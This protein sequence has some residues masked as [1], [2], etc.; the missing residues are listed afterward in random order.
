MKKL[1]LLIVSILVIL[2]STIAVISL[3]DLD[4]R[5]PLGTINAG[6]GNTDNPEARNQWMLDRLKDPAT[7]E[8]PANIKHLEMEFAKKLPTDAGQRNLEWLS[9]GPYNIGGR[10]RAIAMDVNDE[11]RLIAGA[12]TGGV[13]LSEDAGQSW[14]RVTGPMHFPP[15]SCIVQ[16]KRPGKTHIWYYGTGEVRGGYISSQFYRGDG[17]YKS[18]DNGLTWQPLMST[19][20]NNPQATDSEWNFVSR[21]ALDPSVDSLDVIYAST[22]G[23]I[24]RSE[25]GGDTWVKKIGLTSPSIYYS[26]LAVT[27]TGVVYA[28]ADSDAGNGGLWRS[29]GGISWTNITPPGFP[30][31]YDKIV[32]GINP[33]NE[34]EIY[35]LG[36]TPGA[37]QHTQAF[38]GYEEDNS[39][40]K[41]TYVSGNGTGTGANW[42]NL[43]SN[44]PNNGTP[45]DNFYTQWSYN[46]MIAVSP[47]NPNVVMIGA[48]NLYRSTDGFTSMI[49]TTHIGGYWKGS[50]LPSGSWGSYLNH[51]PDQHALLFHPTDSNIIISGND[52]GLYRS[53]NAYDSIVAW[54]RLNN[55]YNTTQAYTVGFDRT[56][57]D[58]VLIGGFQDNANYFVN[59]ADTTALWTM[60]L[61]GDGSYMG[62]APNKD[63]YYLSINRGKIYKMDL[64][65]NG[66]VLDFVRIDPGQVNPDDYLFINPLLMDHNNAD[67]MYV[68]GGRKL[69]RH[70][71]LSS[72]PMTQS[73]DTIFTGW[74]TY[75][76]TINSGSTQISCLAASVSPANILWVGTSNRRLYKII[77]AHTGDPSWQQ[78]PLTTFP[79]GYIS[80]VAIH[81][82]NADT[83]VI[84]LSNYNMYSLFYT[85][86]GGD[87]WQKGAGN[88]EESSSGGGAGPSIGCVEI[89]SRNDGTLYF[90]GTSVGAF[91]TW[92][93]NGYDTE[94]MQ[95][96]TSAF[97]NVIVE[98]IK[99]RQ[100]DGLIAIGT[101]GKGIYTTHIEYVTDLFPL[102]GIEQNSIEM[103]EFNLYP[104]P[105]SEILNIESG[106][107]DM[108]EIEIFDIN[109]KL[110]YRQHLSSSTH[111]LPVGSFVNGTY[112]CRIKTSAGSDTKRFI[113][114]N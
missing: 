85:F 42:L 18:V 80:R 68:G 87:T 81:P 84:T 78:I 76:D 15:V 33:S 25:D 79:A 27:T 40:W 103:T 46:L 83:V 28:T 34:N 90:V 59:T 21:L 57:T 22:A 97:G 69:W 54:N 70:S 93:L 12:T 73:H 36:R 11:T 92:Q 1:N 55:G 98:D 96:G 39:F 52:G 50:A 102:A 19:V 8:I 75:T 105:V 106:K 88:L 108:Q 14:T 4:F 100:T 62:I 94:W 63:Y 60:P 41:F 107:Y 104:N 72:I 37:G 23:G 30:I 109:G 101:Y 38:F 51:H 29:D 17:V 49:N 58:D 48:T 64:D 65:N 71:G 111:S 77:D 31:V 110:V 5:K 35:F 66:E 74:E 47:H 56:D 112:L 53:D 89:L 24:Q 7:G 20:S 113:V 91:V 9:R 26:D 16:D 32:I 3:S 82:Q 67:L 6:D 10:T 99:T 45:F 2:V 43:S 86:D 13:W 61:N 44:I 95:I 114:R